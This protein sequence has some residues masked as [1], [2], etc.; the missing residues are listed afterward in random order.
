[1]GDLTL[2]IGGAIYRG[3]TD[4]R[5]TRSIKRGCSDF[6]ISLTD[7]WPGR[8]TPWPIRGGLPC[9]VLL[10]GETVITGYTDNRAVEFDATAHGVRAAGRSKT[11]DMVD[12]SAI[13]KG[14]QFTNYT[15]P[16]IARAL[17]E[18]FGIGV[19]V[20]GDAGKAFPE[21]QIEPGETCFDIIERLCRL[22][23]LLV[24]DAA[25]GNI[26]LAKPGGF[27]RR[28]T[29][30]V[31]PRGGADG[32]GRRGNIKR[33]RSNESFSQRFSDYIVRGQQA[34]T[35]YSSGASA[36]QP[37]GIAK[38][39]AVPRY[40]PRMIVAEAPGD[41]ASMQRR[42][43]WEAQHAAG[44]SLTASITVYGWRDAS[45]ALWTPGARVPVDSPT[46][47]IAR[48]LV[49]VTASYK[50]S[51]RDGTVA[52]LELQPEN[53]LAPQPVTA[54]AGGAAGPSDLWSDVV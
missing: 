46:L 9:E 15:L 2:K 32:E 44:L 23:G 40:R 51:A 14:G 43:D 24:C 48:E 41:N 30:L 7:K 10:D 49:I 12:G 36:S 8:A 16:A 19:T 27:G 37:Q 20:L 17:A 34:G 26:V 4:I 3:W 54:V 50:R 45:G 35:D 52:E 22:R 38:D 25:S 31:E 33:A 21:V 53:A 28:N 6:D 42:A 5:V 47:G 13:V 39:D 11:M 18:P 1:M 29:A